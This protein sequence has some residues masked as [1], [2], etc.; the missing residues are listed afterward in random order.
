MKSS[1]KKWSTGD[2]NHNPLQYSFLENPMNSM[3]RHI[4]TTPE[5]E[6]PR[7]EGV[8]YATGEERRAS[9]N[10][11]RKN[12]VAGPKWEQCSVVDVSSCERKFSAVKN[13]ST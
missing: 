6:P 12:E 13:N 5:D 3:K 11:F 8:Q 10:S 9:I 1:D 7:S 4:D 2:G